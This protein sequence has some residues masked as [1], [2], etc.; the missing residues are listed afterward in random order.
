MKRRYK[1]SKQVFTYVYMINISVLLIVLIINIY[2]HNINQIVV[3]TTDETPHII[4][5]K[6]YTNLFPIVSVASYS[7]LIFCIIGTMI[8]LYLIYRKIEKRS[9]EFSKNFDGKQ[10]MQIEASKIRS[11][12]EQIIAIAWNEVVEYIQ[13]ESEKRDEYFAAMIHDFKMPLHIIKS[14]IELWS[15]EQKEDESSQMILEEIELLHKSINRFL[16]IDRIVYF[17][18]PVFKKIE[19]INFLNDIINR[20]EFLELKANITSSNTEVYV[21]VDGYMLMHI[22]ENIFSNI[23]SY[24]DDM[25]VEIEISSKKIQFTNT[26]SHQI[27]NIE[28]YQNDV[29]HLFSGGNGIGSQIISTYI[30]LLGW[31][32]KSEIIE[33]QF[34]TIIT[35]DV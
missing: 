7:I 3:N 27:E 2:F 14:N 22:L 19:I 28:I 35:F 10:L 5:T 15:L 25:R 20:L 8:S 23:I 9:I 30:K 33:N 17:E 21:N 1:T 12:E 6:K 18:R 32:V 16:H 11:N 13:A 26:F 31:K 29:R 24:A 4:V 34:T